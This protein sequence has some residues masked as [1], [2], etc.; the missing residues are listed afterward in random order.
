[1]KTTA[2]FRICLQ[3]SSWHVALVLLT[4]LLTSRAAELTNSAAA[5]DDPYLWLE[6]V[7][8]QRALDWVARQNALSTNALQASPGFDA[9][10][11]RLLDILNSRQRIPF[12]EKQGKYY[13]NF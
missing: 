8:G 3:R 7:T 2:R 11:R 4:A 12:V 1:M 6:D 5:P 10:R 13:Y 9:T